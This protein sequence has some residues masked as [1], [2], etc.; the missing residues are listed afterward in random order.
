LFPARQ[1][2]V[3]PATR[4]YAGASPEAGIPRR[5]HLLG[6]VYNEAIK[7]AAQ[8]AGIA[9]QVTSY[10]VRIPELPSSNPIDPGLSLPK[11]TNVRVGVWVMTSGF[12]AISA[13]QPQM[14]VLRI[15]TS[16]DFLRGGDADPD[17]A[18]AVQKIRFFKTIAQSVDRLALRFPFSGVDPGAVSCNLRAR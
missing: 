18:A 4:S 9:K 17:C 12:Q 14:R 2:S 11:K 16:H 8:A 6:K 1:I 5:H 13:I 10:A 3:D 7:R 15:H